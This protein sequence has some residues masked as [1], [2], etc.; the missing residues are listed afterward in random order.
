MRLQSLLSQ[1]ILLVSA[2]QHGAAAA[3]W[4]F[5]DGTVSVAA[6]GAGVGGGLKET[7]APSKPLTSSVKLGAADTLKVVLTTQEGKLA[8][9]PHQAFLLL[10][11]SHGKLDVS[12]PFSVKESG[13]AKVEL[14]H[15]DLPLQFLRSSTPL[16][17]SII[18]ASFGTSE[19]YNGKAFPLTIELDPNVPIPAAETPL[20]YGKLSEIHHV[21]RPDPKSPNI[22]ITLVFLGAVLATLPALL[23]AWLYI[24]GNINHLGKALS[25]A[26]ISHTLFLGSVVGIEGVFFLYYTIW[27]LFKTLPILLALGVVAFLSGSRAL[28]EVQERR[29]AGLR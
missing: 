21:F 22:V 9:R 8:K 13:K 6:K 3:S 4:T 15:K 7:L 24:G 20:R 16:S 17:A 5:T 26:P 27:N 12:F 11:D 18:I 2:L 23:G 19:G 28:T 14:T 1:A 25:D 29:L 10:Q